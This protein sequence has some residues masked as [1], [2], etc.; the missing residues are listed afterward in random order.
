MLLLILLKEE[1]R[2]LENKLKE[3]TKH[4]IVGFIT[5]DLTLW[6]LMGILNYLFQAV[7]I[8]N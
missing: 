2:I 4:T 3:Y 7:I 1:Q 6:F 8:E 5:M